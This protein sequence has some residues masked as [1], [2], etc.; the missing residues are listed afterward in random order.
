M[1]ENK[2]PLTHYDYAD[3]AES[4]ERGEAWSQA[5]YLWRRAADAMPKHPC[6]RLAE[7]RQV[8]LANA[9]RCDRKVVVNNQLEVIAK[10]IL[11]IPT[12]TS[13]HSD[14]LDFH[15]LAVWQIKRALEAAYEAGRNDAS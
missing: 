15:E 11:R 2:K 9:D 3:A 8:Y 10:Q 13:R 1:T 12:L 5:A 6:R 14:S 7:D 4:A